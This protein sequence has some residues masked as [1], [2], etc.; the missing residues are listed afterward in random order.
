MLL[1]HF[2]VP[3]YASKYLDCMTVEGYWDF[4]SFF[5]CKLCRYSAVHC[6]STSHCGFK[7]PKPTIN[8]FASM[9]FTSFSKQ[10]VTDSQNLHFR[11]FYVLHIQN[12]SSCCKHKYDQSI[13]QV[14]KFNFWRDFAFWPN[15]AGG[16]ASIAD[17]YFKTDRGRGLQ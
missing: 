14:F 6:S 11:S 9:F 15:C 13:S 2:S 5:E 12:L 4:F 16:R 1:W 3:Y 8:K 10:V 7:W 17:V